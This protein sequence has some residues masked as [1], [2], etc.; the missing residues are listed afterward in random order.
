MP[1]I[2]VSFNNQCPQKN[3]YA[4]DNQALRIEEVN[5]YMK[6]YTLFERIPYWD[7]SAALRTTDRCGLLDDIVHVKRYVDIMRAKMLFNHLCDEN[8]VWRDELLE[9]F[10]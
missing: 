6:N 2:W 5:K 3:P 8:M 1:N 4:P 7:A 10:I 9:Y